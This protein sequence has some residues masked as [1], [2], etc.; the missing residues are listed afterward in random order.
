LEE[1]FF[2]YAPYKKYNH[3]AELIDN[4]TIKL[5]K[6]GLEVNPSLRLN[7]D[8]I[9]RNS[10]GV[11]KKAYTTSDI[12]IGKSF[13]KEWK[14]REVT[15]EALELNYDQ[16]YS[17]AVLDNIDPLLDTDNVSVSYC[18]KA[19]YYTIN[20]LNLNPRYNKRIK[21]HNYL[22]YIKPS[23]ELIKK[24]SLFY[25]EYKENESSRIVTS[26]NDNDEFNGR[27][28]NDVLEEYFTEGENLH[29]YMPLAYVGLKG[30]VDLEE[31]KVR[32]IRLKK[33]L[34]R[35]NIKHVLKKH[36]WAWYT[37]A[38]LAEPIEFPDKFF[39]SAKIDKENIKATKDYRRYIEEHSA[40]GSTL[41]IE[42]GGLYPRIK[43]I[44]CKADEELEI[45]LMPERPGVIHR[46][47]LLEPGASRPN[48]ERDTLIKSFN[49]EYSSSLVKETVDVESLSL[50]INRFYIVCEDSNT[51]Y[52]SSPSQIFKVR[53]RNV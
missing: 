26:S 3:K 1:V 23:R 39:I 33:G 30:S 37:D 22:L 17:I 46:L 28:L 21:T 9:V 34:N 35:K 4:R 19:S 11:L 16:K 45:I 52:R 25:I 44:N 49:K 15:W 47:Y 18:A 53:I 27:N 20:N 51:G 50:D 40:S 10:E 14:V 32:D 2:P 38:F 43:A 12:K 42:E 36:P 29:Q 24:G 31:V 48:E 8:I 5:P 13:K 6:R 41:I 7:I